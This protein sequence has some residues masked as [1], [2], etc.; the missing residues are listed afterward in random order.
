[1]VPTLALIDQTA[2]AL[3]KSFPTAQIQ[4]ERAEE[5]LLDFDV[6]EMPAISVLTPER[7]HSAVMGG[8]A[9]RF[10]IVTK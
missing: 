5:A 2:K 9:A 7:C 1:M 8:C 3:K 6:E 4:T 10:V